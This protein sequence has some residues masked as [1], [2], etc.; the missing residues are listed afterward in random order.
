MR[1]KCD[2]KRRLFS[3]S[4]TA[5]SEMVVVDREENTSEK[6][7]YKEAF[8]PRQI[9][10]DQID[11]YWDEDYWSDYNIIE[12]TESLENAVEKL[13]RTGNKLSMR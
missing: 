9:F 12:P 8:K 2:M 10:Y 1:F 3:S 11:E 4:Y 7:A 5:N 13:K 6:I